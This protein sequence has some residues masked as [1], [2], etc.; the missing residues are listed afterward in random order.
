MLA[1]VDIHGPEDFQSRVLGGPANHTY[2]IDFWATWCAPCKTLGPIIERATAP[3][4]DVAT[5]VKVNVDENQEIAA[6]FGIQ[7]I[8]A[9]KILRNGELVSEF[10]GAQPETVVRKII[11]EAIPQQEDDDTTRAEKLIAEGKAKKAEPILRKVL[12]A[13]PEHGQ[14]AVLLAGILIGKGEADEAQKLAESVGADS[15]SHGKARSI[16]AR[17]EFML[18]CQ[19]AGGRSACAMTLAA[20]ESD[21][22][23]RYSLA[24]CMAAEGDFQQALEQ[25][26]ECVRRNRAHDEGAARKAMLVIFDMLGREDSMAEEYRTKL[27]RI[28]FS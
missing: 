11:A 14:A 3:F 19:K 23:A 12:E 1:I 22:G 2:V 9:V 6:A 7:S 4:G 17:I 18:A 16:L 21:I 8:P 20:N 28:L 26:L 25:F 27:S 5:L 10:I 15:P 13:T 24:C